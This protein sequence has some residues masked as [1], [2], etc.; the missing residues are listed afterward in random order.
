MT[1]NTNLVL[2]TLK[3]VKAKLEFDLEEQILD[4][5]VND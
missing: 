5:Y 2:D 3:E 4:Q 1:Y